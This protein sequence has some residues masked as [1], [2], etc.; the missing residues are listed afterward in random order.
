MPEIEPSELLDEK[1]AAE[2]LLV[3]PSTLQAWR[4][5]QTYNLPYVQVG[6]RI[7]YRRADLLAFIDSRT[8]H[9]AKED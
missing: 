6:G 9:P 8:I 4:S 3:A 2:L 5:R 7:R 1:Q